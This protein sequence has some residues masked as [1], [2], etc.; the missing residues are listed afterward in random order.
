MAEPLQ[1]RA[2]NRCHGQKLRCSRANF[3]SSCLRCVNAGA[4]CVFGPSMRVR[5]STVRHDPDTPESE[6]V[7]LYQR[8][9]E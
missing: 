8:Y 2:C 1:R 5:M 9:S 7:S 4:A 6:Y 3:G